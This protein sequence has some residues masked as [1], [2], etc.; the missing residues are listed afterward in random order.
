MSK[1]DIIII[2]SGLGGLECGAI[3]SKEG[4]R[5]KSDLGVL[6]AYDMTTEAVVAKLMW[7]LGQ[8]RRRE[9]VERLFYTP[10]ARDILWPGL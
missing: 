2:G 10:V 9:E 5:L 7:I 6:E 4:Y 8:T 1:Y 3:L